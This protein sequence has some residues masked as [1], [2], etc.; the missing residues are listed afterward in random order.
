MLAT[1]NLLAYTPAISTTRFGI[2]IGSVQLA[3]PPVQ[4]LSLGIFVL[5][6]ILNLDSLINIYLDYKEARQMK[7]NTVNKGEQDVL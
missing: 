7:L 6:F 5:Y 4:L 3:T 2:N 1:F